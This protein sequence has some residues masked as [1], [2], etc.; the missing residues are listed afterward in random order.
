MLSAIRMS[1]AAEVSARLRLRG[2]FVGGL[3]KAP[4]F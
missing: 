1:A 3:A 2:S 4:S